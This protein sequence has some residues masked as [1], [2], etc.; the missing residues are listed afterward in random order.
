MVNDGG[1]AML[2]DCYHAGRTTKVAELLA[3][4]P[5]LSARAKSAL[6]GP[7]TMREM[8]MRLLANLVLAMEGEK[9]NG[10][11][12]VVKELMESLQGDDEG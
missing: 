8:L 1:E 10:D 3:N 11:V 5:E 6:S 12:K 2:V 9:R 7:C 4:H